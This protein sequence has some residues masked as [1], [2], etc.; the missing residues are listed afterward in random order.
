MGTQLELKVSGMTCEHC[1]KAVKTA[2]SDVSGV[3][4]V[5]VDLAS[6]TVKV[7]FSGTAKETEVREAIAE[8]GYDVT[9]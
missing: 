9:S 4:S 1:K 7:A 3:S 6:G 2:V 8:A 5:D